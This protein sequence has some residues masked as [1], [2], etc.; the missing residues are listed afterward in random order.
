MRIKIEGTAQIAHGPPFN[1][2]LGRPMTSRNS[3]NRSEAPEIRDETRIPLVQR[4]P[5]ESE[6][7]QPVVGAFLGAFC[8]VAGAR[9][10]TQSDL[11]AFPFKNSSQIPAI[12]L[13]RAREF[14]RRSKCIRV[15]DFIDE[16]QSRYFRSGRTSGG[17]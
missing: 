4:H 10:P 1:S 11:L 3:R 13:Y 15:Y 9:P 6:G 17:L 16:T 7:S 5:E 2:V 14:G 8:E 12:P